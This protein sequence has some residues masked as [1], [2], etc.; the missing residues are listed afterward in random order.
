M[1]KLPNSHKFKKYDKL[2]KVVISSFKIPFLK[3][4]F[5]L[6]LKIL[7]IQL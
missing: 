7:Y 3:F 5:H 1:K 2:L 4:K 6:F